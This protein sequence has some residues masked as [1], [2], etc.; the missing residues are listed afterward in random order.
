[1]LVSVCVVTYNSSQTVIET[2]ESIKQQTY[3]NIEL[4]ISDD[5][6]KDNTVELC[7]KWALLN[8]HWF[9]KIKIL[10]SQVNTGVP[11]NCNRAIRATSAM[12]VKLIAADDLLLM[13]CISD[14]IKF[15]NL[16][17]DAKI[18]YSYYD[19]F[20]QNNNGK[21]VLKN[22][23]PIQSFI[24]KF[25]KNPS[26]QFETYIK[27]SINITPALFYHK[28]IILELGGFDEQYRFFEDT[29]MLTKILRHNIFI[30]FLNKSTVLYRIDTNSITRFNTSEYF[31][32]IDFVDCVLSFKKKEIYPIIPLKNIRFWVD[33]YSFRYTYYFV[34][35]VLKN[36][37][38]RI[39]ITLYYLIK[40]LNPY[41]L[42]RYIVHFI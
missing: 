33:E 26:I 14:Y 30:Y 15:I 21:I 13:N 32:K 36:N 23:R 27:Y 28:D 10:R 8:S 11:G 5:Y 29:P 16:Y 7:E 1:M 6:S 39:T 40:I 20:I 35:H 9:N 3:S 19:E 25:S 24:E 12:W 2:L 38:N 41:Y 22:R 34:K 4:I 17:P 18:I 42:Y 31:Y 37:K